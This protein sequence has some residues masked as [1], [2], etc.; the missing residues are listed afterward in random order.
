V[1]QRF[2]YEEID[3]EAVVHAQP[4]DLVS[5]GLLVTTTYTLNPK[6]LKPTPYTPAL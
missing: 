2:A 4:A 6:P 5:L 1:R 3:V